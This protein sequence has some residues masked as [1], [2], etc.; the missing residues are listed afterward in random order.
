MKKR[1]NACFFWLSQ[2]KEEP[3]LHRIVTCDEKW[4]IYDNPKRLAS[5]L[6]K[7][8][9]PRYSP[10]SNNWNQIMKVWEELFNRHKIFL[11]SEKVRAIC[12]S[13]V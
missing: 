10:K 12:Q 11:F 8:R 3:F 4:V 1:F 9:A 2:N 5:W 7:D 13:E 6:D